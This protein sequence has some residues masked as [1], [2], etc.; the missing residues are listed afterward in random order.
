MSN[1]YY[2]CFEC[3]TALRRPHVY[4]REKPPRAGLPRMRPMLHLRYL[5][6]RHSAQTAQ[7]RMAAVA[8]GY[9]AIPTRAARLFRQLPT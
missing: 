5:Q 6:T 7:I 4:G 2:V 3:R 8:G 1:H 9:A